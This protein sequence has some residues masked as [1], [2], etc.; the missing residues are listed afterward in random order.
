MMVVFEGLVS[1]AGIEI[2]SA[3]FEDAEGVLDVAR[4]ALIS[5]TLAVF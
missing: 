1:A 3:F 5:S 2:G 4:F